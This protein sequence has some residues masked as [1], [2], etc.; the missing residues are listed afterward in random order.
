MTIEQITS[1]QEN[2][3]TLR[4][5]ADEMAERLVQQ[6]ADYI[7]SRCNNRGGEWL[8]KSPIKAGTH[9]YKGYRIRRVEA[10]SQEFRNDKNFYMCIECLERWDYDKQEDF[11]WQFCDYV[12]YDGQHLLGKAGQ[13]NG[14]VGM[15]KKILESK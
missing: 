12:D 10:H 13:T 1:T 5:M 9:T 7:I 6:C 4:K 3:A 2:I 14:Y 8:F 11:Y 15:V